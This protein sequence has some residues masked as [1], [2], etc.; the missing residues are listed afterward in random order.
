MIILKKYM[1]ARKQDYRKASNIATEYAIYLEEEKGW[2]MSLIEGGVISPDGSTI[3]HFARSP[4]NGQLSQFNRDEESY[5][6]I[7]KELIS[8]GEFIS[9]NNI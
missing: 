2:N 5:K 4:Y 1:E 3:Y 7:C 9:Y 6:N 8:K